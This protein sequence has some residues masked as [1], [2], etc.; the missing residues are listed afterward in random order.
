MQQQR[1][2]EQVP[3]VHTDPERRT[4]TGVLDLEDDLLGGS[5]A[6]AAVLLRPRHVEPPAR[7]EL[8]LPREANVPVGVVGRAARTEMLAELADEVIVEPRP[9]FVAEGFVVGAQ[10]EVHR[11]TSSKRV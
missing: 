3:P 11:S 5:P 9:Q 8:A 4:G 1:W 2:T 6:A 7:G 10:F